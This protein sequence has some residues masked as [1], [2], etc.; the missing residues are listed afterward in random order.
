[1]REK[2]SMSVWQHTFSL[3][4][5]RLRSML[6]G[7]V[8][9]VLLGGLSVRHA[10]AAGLTAEQVR[11]VILMK[12]LGY[13]R[14]VSSRSGTLVV[15]VV[16]PGNG[17]AAAEGAAMYDALR[18]TP[19]NV[20][21]G[22]SLQVRKVAFDSKDQVQSSLAKQGAEVVY[23]PEGMD[24]LS[25]SLRDAGARLLILCGDPTAVGKGCLMSVEAQSQGSRLV[26]DARGAEEAGFSFDAR[27]LRL[28]RVVR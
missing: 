21:D 7:C 5:G 10:A 26:L 2:P 25:A 18:L 6:V 3:C 15:A 13:E 4:V 8:A 27:L 16:V 9:L 1:M 22:R 23:V 17:P 12:A 24:D 20:V 14:T 11:S 19:G 28:S